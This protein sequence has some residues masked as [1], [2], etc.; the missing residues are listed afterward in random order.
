[1]SSHP[2]HWANINQ[3]PQTKPRK[4]GPKTGELRSRSWST[5]ESLETRLLQGMAA[6]KALDMNRRT[7]SFYCR[8]AIFAIIFSVSLRAQ[9]GS[10]T[11]AQ[12][13]DHIRKVEDGVDEF[14]KYLNNRGDDAKDRVDSA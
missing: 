8:A 6:T 7:R 5:K 1:M 3:Q 9:V 10:F 11:K 12:V 14:Q 4:G 13:G 2:V